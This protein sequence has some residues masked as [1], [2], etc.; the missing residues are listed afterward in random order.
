MDPAPARLADGRVVTPELYR[1]VTAEELERIRKLV[2]DERY[3][4][5]RFDL[6]KRLFDRLITNPEFE[7][8]LTLPAYE[9]L[10]KLE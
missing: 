1:V 2:G 5:G 10:L 7:D 8:F 9:E 4:T 6:A 3:R